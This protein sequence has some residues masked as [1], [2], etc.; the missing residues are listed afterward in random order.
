MLALETK[1]AKMQTVKKVYNLIILDESGSMESIKG[2]TIDGFNELT[3][4]IKHSEKQDRTI[5]QFIQFHSFNGAGLKELFKLA[6][7]HYIKSLTSKE[8]QPE[9]MTPLYDAIGFSVNS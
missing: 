8:Y 4:S 9:N 7:A 2:A 6:P 5:E 1:P 3:Q